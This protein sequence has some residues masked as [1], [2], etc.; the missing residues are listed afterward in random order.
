MKQVSDNIASHEGPSLLKL[1]Q[2]KMTLAE[3]L[4][5]LLRLD[6][7]IIEV[8]EEDG[9]DEEV[10]QADVFRE[11]IGLCIL[12]IDCTLTQAN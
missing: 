11:R 5:V 8:V 6:G 2:H 3:K 1:R 4:E 9:L 12:D 7:E 10:E